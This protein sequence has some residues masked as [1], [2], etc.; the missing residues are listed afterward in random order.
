MCGGTFGAAGGEAF[1]PAG[2]PAA[3]AAAAEA[4]SGLWL[5]ELESGALPPVAAPGLERGLFGAWAAAGGE[6]VAA[7][8]AAPAAD[9]GLLVGEEGGGQ[10]GPG[11]KKQA[12]A[13]V[14]LDELFRWAGTAL[15]CL[16]KDLSDCNSCSGR[17]KKADQQAVYFCTGAPL[18]L[19][20]TLTPHVAPM[21]ACAAYEI[22]AIL[23]AHPHLLASVQGIVERT[24]KIL[25]CSVA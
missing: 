4:S 2:N 11:P 24:C 20:H 19:L 23:C 16:L 1:D 3:A 10:Q 18:L 12:P 25:I 6:A 7:V 5:A 9:G 8:R 14:S 17:K 13:K 21:V 15:N 22:A